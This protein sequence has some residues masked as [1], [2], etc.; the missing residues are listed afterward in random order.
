MMPNGKLNIFYYG[1]SLQYRG[2]PVVL[3]VPGKKNEYAI[4]ITAENDYYYFSSL[5]LREFL[6]DMNRDNG[7]GDVIDP[8]AKIYEK[9]HLFT[10]ILPVRKPRITGLLP[11]A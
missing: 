2:R 9:R 11:V 1:D 8:T 3:P 5:G 7:N 4:F 6:V 10:D